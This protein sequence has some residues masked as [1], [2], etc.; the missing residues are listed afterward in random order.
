MSESVYVSEEALS[1]VLEAVARDLERHRRTVAAIVDAV[2]DLATRSA[3]ETLDNS[4]P[5][6]L[7][8]DLVDAVWAALETGL[9][10]EVD[11]TH[12]L[13]QRERMLAQEDAAREELLHH[14]MNGSR[15][16]EDTWPIDQNGEGVPQ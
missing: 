6:Y 11:D 8:E 1:T 15:F 16:P 12:P 5:A 2:S 14:I 4:A 10:I 13:A 7:V 3:G 9:G